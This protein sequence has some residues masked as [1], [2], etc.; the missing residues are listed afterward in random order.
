MTLLI[1]KWDKV[2]SCH[3][4]ASFQNFTFYFDT[5]KTKHDMYVIATVKV[6]L[7]LQSKYY[8]LWSADLRSL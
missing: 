7:L 2:L 1:D 3:E 4:C 8:Q 6:Q 5:T